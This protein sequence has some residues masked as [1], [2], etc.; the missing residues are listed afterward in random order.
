MLQSDHNSTYDPRHQRK[1]RALAPERRP[2]I[3]DLPVAERLHRAILE[4]TLT[5]GAISTA[6]DAYTTSSGPPVG[7]DCKIQGPR[8]MIPEQLPPIRRYARE[9]D[10]ELALVG[11]KSSS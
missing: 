2:V 7:P 1:L 10:H 11:Q 8:R 5:S 3:V 6:P 9:Q 4:G